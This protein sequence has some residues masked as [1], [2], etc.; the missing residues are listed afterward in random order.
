SSC[1]RR[2]TTVSSRT[3]QSDALDASFSLPSLLHNQSRLQRLPLS[4]LHHFLDPLCSGDL[5]QSLQLL[6]GLLQFPHE[7][8]AIILWLVVILILAESSLANGDGRVGGAGR[9]IKVVG[10]IEVGGASTDGRSISPI[11]S[12]TIVRTRFERVIDRRL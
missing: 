12:D 11:M 10:N 4:L 2:S 6:F 1:S 7:I 8:S 9:D 5:L 3:T